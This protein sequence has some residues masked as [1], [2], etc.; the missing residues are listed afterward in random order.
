M[1]ISENGF[2]KP[3]IDLWSIAVILYEM[4]FKSLPLFFSRCIGPEI[5]ETWRNKRDNN[6]S[7][8][9]FLKKRRGIRAGEEIISW[10]GIR[11]L[12]VDQKDR[13]SLRALSSI[14]TAI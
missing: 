10:I 8:Y 7:I 13:L 1:S 12:Q 5:V 11:G 9:P 14:L 6:F 4:A 3:E 2:N